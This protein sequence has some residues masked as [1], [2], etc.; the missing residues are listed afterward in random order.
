MRNRALPAR[1][2]L[3]YMQMERNRVEVLNIPLLLSSDTWAL[4]AEEMLLYLMT[5]SRWILPRGHLNREELSQLLF[6]FLGMASDIMD[7]FSLFESDNIRADMNMTYTLLA[8]WSWSV[9]QF[10]LTFYTV[11]H[12]QRAQGVANVSAAPDTSDTKQELAATL[13]SLFMQDGP[14]LVLRMYAVVVYK[15][16]T[17]SM[18]FF[19]AKNIVV[20]CLLLYK[21]I[22]LCH[23]SREKGNENTDSERIVSK[24]VE[25]AV[26]DNPLTSVSDEQQI[27]ESS[28]EEIDNPLTSVCDERQTDESSD[29]ETDNPLTSVS[30]ERQTEESSDEETDDIKQE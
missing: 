15:I 13:V 7:I 29:E 18:I 22:V 24:D 9:L 12:P 11:H 2:R 8:V 16:I 3:E 20:I 19:V 25:L 14:F 5:L 21:I 27:E 1:D 23:V 26:F 4:V 28:D 6:A 17:H 10:S 30:D